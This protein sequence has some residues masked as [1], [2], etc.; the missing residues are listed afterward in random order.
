MLD[1]SVTKSYYYFESQGQR[2]YDYESTT[3]RLQSMLCNVITQ[4]E[5][6]CCQEQ[7]IAAF[8]LSD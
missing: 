1:K 3:C 5:Q 6:I 2:L 4:S 7:D 8:E